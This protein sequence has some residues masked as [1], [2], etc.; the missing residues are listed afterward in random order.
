MVSVIFF[1]MITELID[2]V[3][4]FKYMDMFTRKVLKKSGTIR[5]KGG[6]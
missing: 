1:K 2:P 6:V 5:E 3:I 4:K